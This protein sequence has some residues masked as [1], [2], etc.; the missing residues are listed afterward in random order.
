GVVKVIVQTHITGHPELNKIGVPLAGD[1]ARTPEQKAILELYFTQTIF[2]RPYVVAPEVP[3]D[4]VAA[5][6][7]AFTDTLHDPE[8]IAEAKKLHFDVD[9]VSGDELERIVGKVY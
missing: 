2:G 5:L 9:Q 1:F 8:L 6:R 4:R 3:A 7:Q